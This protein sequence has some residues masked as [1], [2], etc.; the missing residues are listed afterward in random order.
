MAPLSAP[1]QQGPGPLVPP[2]QVQFPPLVPPPRQASQPQH[3]SYPMETRRGQQQ[4]ACS[5]PPESCPA[6]IL[7]QQAPQQP[8][9]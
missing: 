3:G 5:Q 7:R 1:E 8:L 6:A 4:P 2:G 9:A